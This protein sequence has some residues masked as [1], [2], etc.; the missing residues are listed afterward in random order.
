[1]NKAVCETDSCSLMLSIKNQKSHIWKSV[2]FDKKKSSEYK[3][4]IYK[5]ICFQYKTLY[6][7]FQ[8]SEFLQ[9]SYKH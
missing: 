5:L 2:K 9:Q 8:H 1:M 3:K 4:G 6:V 7:R